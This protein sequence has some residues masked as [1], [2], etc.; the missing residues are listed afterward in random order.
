MYYRSRIWNKK[1]YSNILKLS[2]QVSKKNI[3][4][5]GTLNPLIRNHLPIYF[6][7]CVIVVIKVK[8]TINLSGNGEN[9]ERV[10][11]ERGMGQVS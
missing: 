9:M 2:K 3:N 5:W 4:M 10:G 1:D 8:G 6:Y 7:V 11:G